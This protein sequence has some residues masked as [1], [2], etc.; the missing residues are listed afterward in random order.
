MKLPSPSPQTKRS[1][2]SRQSLL[3]A[4]ALCLLQ[5]CSS[6]S[7]GG[8]D[9]VEPGLN[10]SG[11]IAADEPRAVLVGNEILTGG[12]LAADAAAAMYFTLAITYPQAAGLGGGGQCLVFNR[13]VNKTFVLEF[14]ARTPRQGGSIALPGNVRGMAAL[15][16]RF[17]KLRWGAV[18]GPA[19]ALARLGGPLPRAA[20]KAI[21][22]LSAEDL[23]KAAAAPYLDGGAPLPE[24]TI[25]T[26]GEVATT[27]DAM[28]IG[29][30]N[31]FYTGAVAKAFIEGANAVGGAITAEDMRSVQP[32][33]RDAELIDID[34]RTIAFGSGKGADM[35]RAIWNEAVSAGGRFFGSPDLK[36]T[37]LLP[38]MATAAAKLSGN[39]P[40]SDHGSTAF[41]VIDWTGNAVSCGFTLR[42]GFGAGYWI[43]R[44][45]ILAAPPAD[46]A[47]DPTDYLGLM[48]V[49]GTA[50]KQAYAAVSAISGAAT[51]AVLVQVSAELLAEEKSPEKALAE[52]RYFVGGGN[53][54]YREQKAQPLPGA[55]KE[56]EALGRANV[57][58]CAEG[59]PRKPETCAAGADLREF[60]AARV[61]VK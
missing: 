16:N 21:S 6:P 25:L 15:Q 27:L 57:A 51:P 38:A 4:G 5:A 12:G 2:Q 32:V 1:A 33:W 45:G 56:V 46:P 47:Y 54:G 60:G 53:V 3:V 22:S 48:L 7:K 10:F 20:A 35:A 23:A 13:M 26:Y 52:P 61:S 40:I 9:A 41:S 42:Q 31:E 11:V 14:P 44:T 19:Q 30:P 18:I 58:Y 39:E 29:G 37:K 50:A 55:Q 17:G 43:G 49:S 8:F 28:R 36:R 34:S 24:G 59:L